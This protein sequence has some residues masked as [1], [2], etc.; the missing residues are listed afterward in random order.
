MPSRRRWTAVSVPRR[1][2]GATDSGR[3]D[4]DSGLGSITAEPAQKLTAGPDVDP[5]SQATLSDRVA[6]PYHSASGIGATDGMRPDLVDAT[7]GGQIGPP[8]NDGVNPYA[9][10][11]GEG[12]DRAGMSSADTAADASTDPPPDSSGISLVGSGSGSHG[13]QTVS[14]DTSAADAAP[15]A[16]DA[17]R[18]SESFAATG[19]DDDDLE[20]LQVQRYVNPDAA[21]GTSSIAPTDDQLTHVV[22]SHGDATDVV[23]GFAP[24]QIEGQASS[25]Q[26]ID[27]VGNPSDPIGS[28]DVSTITVAPPGQDISHTINPDIGFGGGGSPSL[29]PRPSAADDSMLYGSSSSAATV[30]TAPP[31]TD[32]GAEAKI[33][34][35]ETAAGGAAE[36][37]RADETSI[38]TAGEAT[39]AKVAASD[40]DPGAAEQARADET[41]ITTAGEATDAKVAASDQDPGAAEQARADET[42]VAGTGD[43]KVDSADPDPGAAEQA[44]ADETST[45]VSL[46]VV[47]VI[48]PVVELQPVDDVALPS[49]PVADATINPDPAPFEAPP[50]SFVDLQVD[51]TV[52]IPAPVDLDDGF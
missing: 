24:A 23:M 8:V 39:D 28:V 10:G 50:E 27:L 36:Q 15:A 47:D 6:D 30:A 11:S 45:D 32:S 14:G 37:A 51:D 12:G 9:T 13:I 33:G 34:A 2:G 25:S 43:A 18:G 48:A 21:G 4:L 17:T 31:P 29:A 20:E 46:T 3:G 1:V 44:R 22:T 38:T 52:A 41:S 26:P 5:D 7:G 35:D 40:Q 42:S 16:A 49:D 19:G